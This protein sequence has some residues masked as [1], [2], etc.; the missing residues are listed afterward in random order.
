MNNKDHICHLT[1]AHPQHDV[2]ILIKEC[3][4][5]AKHYNT[6][7]IV[8]NGK[9]EIFNNVNIININ[10]DYSSRIQRFTKVVN[11]VLAKAIIV[12]A[13]IYHIH[14]PELLRIVPKLKRLNKKIIYDVHEDLP[15]QILSKPWINITIRKVIAN[16]VEWYENKISKKCDGII[17]ATPFIRDRFLKLNNNTIDIN[18]FPII[19]E[20]LLD[21][22]YSKKAD[23]NICYV[24]GITKIRGI[25]EIVKSIESLDVKLL[26]A[27]DFLENTLKEE[28]ALL[29]GWSKVEE[30]GFVDRK[31]V[32]E[33]YE[34][35]KL[36]LVTLHPVINYIDS[37]PVKMFE[38][39]AAGIPVVASNFPLWKGLVE[40]N[41]C[42]ICADPLDP[43]EIGEAIKYLLENPMKAKIMGE[44]GQKIVQEKYNW[45]NEE[46]KM[47]NFYSKIIE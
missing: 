10:Y 28:T 34:K 26:L 7:L 30:L 21:M 43:K 44:N 20:L 29:D 41:Q 1:S 47:L 46:K 3:S 25:K 18:N 12:D 40:K 32:K 31:Q 2:R 8:V 36:G 42:G 38:Y 11:L 45:S 37:L 39:M 4:S 35:S 15:R 22:E 14:D 9:D 23:N 16:F 13:D 19:E 5:L 33:I 27:G 24:G 17:A 6:S